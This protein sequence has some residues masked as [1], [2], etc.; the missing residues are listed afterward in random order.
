M[1]VKRQPEKLHHP[2]QW[3]VYVVSDS[4]RKSKARKQPHDE[5]RAE[6]VR[7]DSSAES[8]VSETR[9]ELMTLSWGSHSDYGRV[10]TGTRVSPRNVMGLGGVLTSIKSCLGGSHIDDTL[11]NTELMHYCKYT[12]HA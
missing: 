9:G 1:R 4:D 5:A 3:A 8:G 2:S 11:R 7:S 6:S 10:N 12:F